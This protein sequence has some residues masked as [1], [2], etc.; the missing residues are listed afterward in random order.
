MKKAI[1]AI[2]AADAAF[3]LLLMLSGFFDGIL[4]YAFY[5][6]SLIL[7]FALGILVSRDLSCNNYLHFGKREA[8]LTLPLIP[9]T[10]FIIVI[11]SVLTS[12][13][14]EL[15]GLQDN[16][17]LEGN[18][19]EALISYALIPALFEELL[20]RYLPL[21]VL[22]HHSPRITVLISAALFA[23]V[24]LDPFRIFYAFVAGA[25]LMSIDI[26]C[27]SVFPSVIIHFVNNTLS[28]V[29]FFLDGYE[30]FAPAYISALLAVSV[31]AAIYVYSRRGEY[32]RLFKNTLYK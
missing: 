9:L 15:F 4:F 24:H 8:R 14:L 16:T 26:M 32:I 27:E 11:I 20:F 7:P 31:F 17:V 5:A 2:C 13:A 30:L 22:S 10:V 25:I 12:L 29:S 23:A 6:I 3:L 18:F 21:R 19:F 28:V 1:I